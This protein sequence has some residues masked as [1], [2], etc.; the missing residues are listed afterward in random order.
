M[1]QQT[2]TGRES[3][4]L[5]ALVHQ[6]VGC[7]IDDLRVVVDDDGLT[8]RGRARTAVARVLAEVEAA[9]LSGLPVVEN[10]IELRPR[11]SRTDK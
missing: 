7:Q 6:R 5:A 4:R 9:R 11:T 3:A 10:R 1:L 2:I 8:L